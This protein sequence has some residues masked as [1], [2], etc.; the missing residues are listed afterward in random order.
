MV[1]YYKWKEEYG[2]IEGEALFSMP[3]LPPCIASSG[4]PVPTSTPATVPACTPTA[5]PVARLSR[6]VPR[7]G[8]GAAD[9]QSLP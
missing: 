1:L 2:G 7:H 5:W 6:V 4:S 9:Y 3:S 8:S